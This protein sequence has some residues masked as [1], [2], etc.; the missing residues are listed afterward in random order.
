MPPGPLLEFITQSL[1]Q[2]RGTVQMS[3]ELAFRQPASRS[4]SL[5]FQMSIYRTCQVWGGIAAKVSAPAA[6]L[7]L[8]VGCHHIDLGTSRYTQRWGPPHVLRIARFGEPTSLNPLFA[9]DQRA[10]DTATLYTETLTTVDGNNRLVPLLATRVPTRANGDITHD[11][12]TITY[13]LRH[14]NRFADGAPLTSRDVVFTYRAIMDP[15]N[16]VSTVTPYYQIVSINTPDLYT[17]RIHLRRPWAAAVSELFAASDWAYGILPAHA[18]ANNP[19]IA[20]AEWNQRPFGSGPFR[21]VTWRHADE[22]VLQPNPYARR[23]P[24]LKELIIKIVPDTNSSLIALQT[25]D[26]DITELDQRQIQQVQAMN[27]IRVV[28]TPLNQTDS[29]WFETQRFPTDDPRVRRAIIEA[30]DREA[31]LKKIYHD[32]AIPANTEIP[33]LLWAHDDA[34]AQLAYSPQRA[35][36]NLDAAGWR[37]QG[38][39]RMK[40]GKALEITVAFDS[41]GLL[42]LPTLIQEQLQ[43]VGIRAILR[44]YPN[45][46]LNAPAS[47]GGIYAGGRFNLIFTGWTGGVDPEASEYLTCNL[48]P[49]NGD[50]DTGWCDAR[51]DHLFALQR[52]DDNLGTRRAAFFGMQRLVHDAYVEDFLTNNLTDMAVNADVVNFHPNMLFQYW[53]SDEWDVP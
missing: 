2:M 7:L 31:I 23:K 32:L 20:H 42:R 52:T 15:R 45:A 14:D 41:A 17:V 1:K 36:S 13:H 35:A 24:R 28:R 25:H 29:L 46:L 22:I 3:L 10:M 11:G 49:P 8:L 37:S 21:V 39:V 47:S 6:L 53:N 38:D 5:F 30:I 43:L 9:N 34:I 40:N 16:P 26:I 44:G 12:L 4:A 18:F 33:S 50:N 48:K 51:Y 19:N 27:G